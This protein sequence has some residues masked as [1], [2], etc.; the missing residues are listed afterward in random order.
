MT[1]VSSSPPT[2]VIHFSV[3]AS[4]EC[5]TATKLTSL[6]L[7]AKLRS[8]M[9]LFSATGYRL[10]AEDRAYRVLI[11]LHGQPQWRRKFMKVGLPL[12]L[13]SCSSGMEGACAPTSGTVEVVTAEGNFQELSSCWK[14]MVIA[15]SYYILLLTELIWGRRGELAWIGKGSDEKRD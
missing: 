5:E 3:L 10:L 4:S 13:G 7:P 9:K 14:V 12:E 1:S 15:V 8:S 11:C 6:C 2:D